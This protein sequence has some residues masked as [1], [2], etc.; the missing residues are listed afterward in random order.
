MPKRPFSRGAL[1]LYL[2]LGRNNGGGVLLK[3]E[4]GVG[5]PWLLFV[6]LKLLV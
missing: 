4:I 5:G 3:L 1:V 2:V 6:E